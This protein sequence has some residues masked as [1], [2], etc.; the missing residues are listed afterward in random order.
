MKELLPAELIRLAQN[1]PVPLYV[2]GGSVRDYLAGLSA[3]KSDWDICSPYPAEEFAE[4]AKQNG[5][6]VRA[7]YKNTGTVKIVGQEAEYEYSS[8]RSDE[9]VRGAHAPVN[10][11]FTADI[12]LDAKR[13]DF[14][15]NAV[16]YHIKKEQFVDP[17]EGIS[18]IKER[19]LTTVDNAK[20]VFGEDGLR[21]MRLA[22][23][24]AQLGFTPDKACLQG[25]KENASLITDISPE[26]IFEE[27][28]AILTADKKCGVR[29][30]AYRGLSLLAEIGVLDL[31]L[32][33]L[34]KGRS[35]AQR[36]DFHK[37]D[38]LEHSLR[39]VRYMEEISGEYPLRLAALLHDVGKPVCMIE[40]G[41]AHGH[42]EE[43]EKIVEEILTRLKAPKRVIKQIAWL[44]KRHMYDFNCKT[45]ENKLRRFFVKNYPQIEDLLKIKQA[46]FSACADDISPAPTCVRWRKL[47][48]QMKDEGVPFTVK[49]LAVSGKELA[50]YGVPTPRLAETLNALLAHT[51]VF[52]KD[53][54]KARLLKIAKGL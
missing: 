4:I 20:K 40:Q 23:Q 39:A 45:G 24:A 22:R 15:A 38:V 14:T 17:L 16:Y 34:T 47:L 41:N 33:E 49:G 8:F 10:V 5:F 29:D 2:V 31:I 21:L 44:T 11:Y 19:R 28:L 25:A 1:H 9:Y 26:R 37:Y 48:A 42:D 32:P 27:L 12:R 50:E 13:R 54:T 18:A 6:S 35:L 53:N 7:V 52:P 30:A 46:D 43:G 3:F 51:A 36:A